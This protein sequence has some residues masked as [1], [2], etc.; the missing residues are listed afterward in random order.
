MTYRVSG[1]SG[2]GT[3]IAVIVTNVDEVNAK[4]AEFRED[5]FSEMAVHDL[6]GNP[7]DV[8]MFDLG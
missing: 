1:K 3:M 4:L 7:I 2:I 5:G 6:D 8:T